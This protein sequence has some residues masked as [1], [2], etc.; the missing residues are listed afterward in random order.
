MEIKRFFVEPEKL[1]GSVA[2]IDNGEFYHMTRVLRL[3]KGYKIIV[4][5]GD[6][7]DYYGEID[8][9]SDG[10]ATVK[11]EKS[12]PNQTALPFDLTMLQAIPARDKLE[13]IV[14][15]AVETGVKRFIPFV[16]RHVNDGS[17]NLE[18]LK[19]IAREAAKQ[20]GANAPA[21]V[22]PPVSFAEAVREA[23]RSEVAIAAYERHKGDTVANLRGR[24]KKDGFSVSFM[25]GAEGGFAAEEAEYMQKN[26][27]ELV[28][29]GRRV[30]RCETAGVV[31][32]AL[33]SAVYDLQCGENF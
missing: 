7:N 30:L 26:G 14:Q 13:I 29:L 15:K 10:C 17:V 9:V 24:F 27:V 33:I 20:C 3:K 2:V 11:I 31:V 12:L 18:R 19:K 32:S 8:G 1:N 25:I 6:G 5:T 21:E 16:S 22:L 23:K 28:T 4:C